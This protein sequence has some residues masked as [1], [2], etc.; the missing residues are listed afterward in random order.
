[1]S[2]TAF[3]ETAYYD[4]V[5]SNYFNNLCDTNFPKK[6]TIYANLIEKLRYGKT[7]IKKVQFIQKIK[8]LVYHKLMG[9]S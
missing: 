9:N 8:K 3:N 7:L 5:I 4:S 2:Q 1:M 6:K